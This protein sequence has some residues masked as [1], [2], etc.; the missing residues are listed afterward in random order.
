MTMTLRMMMRMVLCGRWEGSATSCGKLLLTLTSQLLPG[1]HLDLDP[2]HDAFGGCDDDDHHDDDRDAFDQYR[3]H[4]HDDD[5]DSHLSPVFHL[6]LDLDH[7]DVSHD[8]DH[9]A[10]MTSRFCARVIRYPGGGLLPL[11]Y[12]FLPGGN[13]EGGELAKK[14]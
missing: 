11:I 1:L 3:C 2:H 8:Y 4:D 6:S 9:Y 12:T 13:A 14:R 10:M 5:G 7:I